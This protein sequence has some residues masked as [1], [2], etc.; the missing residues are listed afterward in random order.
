MK[1]RTSPCAPEAAILTGLADIG[2]MSGENGMV[3]ADEERRGGAPRQGALHAS[4]RGDL[5]HKAEGG[6]GR[7]RA[8]SGEDISRQ[9]EQELHRP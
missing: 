4:L 1:R 7:D 5:E 6:E 9:D 2:Q 8:G 3:H